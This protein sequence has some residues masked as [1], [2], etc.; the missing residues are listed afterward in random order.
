MLVAGLIRI[1]PA[2]HFFAVR[3]FVSIAVDGYA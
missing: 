3:G 2:I 1:E